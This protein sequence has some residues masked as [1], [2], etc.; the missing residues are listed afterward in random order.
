[1]KMYSIFIPLAAVAIIA[2]CGN[3]LTGKAEAEK[4]IPIFHTL[5]DQ[6]KYAE[7]YSAADVGF[8]KAISQEK[9]TQILEAV[10]RKLGKVKSAETGTWNMKTWNTKTYVTISQE[11]VFENGTGTETFT[12]IIR[13]GKALLQS[14][15]INSTDLI[16]K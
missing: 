5:L 14:Y 8:T 13:D 12:Y 9:W 15:N 1:M 3:M 10:H 2:G 11:T 16:T 4:A 7:I 6:E